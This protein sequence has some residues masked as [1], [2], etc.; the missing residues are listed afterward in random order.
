MEECPDQPRPLTVGAY[1]TPRAPIGGAD[2]LNIRAT[3]RASPFSSEHSRVDPE[4][5]VKLAEGQ[6]AC[7]FAPRL[8]IDEA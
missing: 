2:L 3:V 1:H 7:V 5:V 4:T 6:Y 8:D